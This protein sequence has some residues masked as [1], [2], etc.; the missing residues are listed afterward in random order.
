MKMEH[1]SLVAYLEARRDMQEW[2]DEEWNAATAVIDWLTA[3]L[4]AMEEEVSRKDAKTQR[5]ND[6]DV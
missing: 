2:S 5:E 3:Q 4:G 6:A 1:A